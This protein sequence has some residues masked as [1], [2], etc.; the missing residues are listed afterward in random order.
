MGVKMRG[1]KKYQYRTE[2]GYC[3]NKANTRMAK[4]KIFAMR[5]PFNLEGMEVAMK[6]LKNMAE[7]KGLMYEFKGVN[8]DGIRI[9]QGN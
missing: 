3:Y 2:S 8:L 7:G 9:H 6:V 4:Y 1:K 5:K